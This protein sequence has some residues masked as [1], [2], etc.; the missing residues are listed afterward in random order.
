MRIALVC[1]YSMGHWGGVQ[2][3]AANLAR[4]LTEAGH[5]AW[6]VAPDAA[7]PDRNVGSSRVIRFNRSR[8]PLA[9]HPA[10][11]SAT[12]AAV[13]DAD[14]VHVHEPFMPL[15]SLAA[16]LGDTPPKVGTFHADAGAAVRALYRAGSPVLRRWSRRLA[17][18]TAVSPV[19]QRSVAS[20]VE[21]EIVPNA[22]DVA[23]YDRDVSRRAD[24]VVFVGRD[25]PRKGLDILLTAWVRAGLDAELLVIGAARDDAPA[26]VTFLGRVDED[27]K[28]DLLASASILCAPNTGEESFGLVVAE[29]MAAGCAVVASGIP[30]FAAVLGGD[31]RLVPPGDADALAKTLSNLL[32]EPEQAAAL[33]AAAR[34]AVMRF[35]RSAVVEAYLEAYARAVGAPTG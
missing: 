18:A 31:G 25:D 3:Q 30:A 4:W 16:L 10:A 22:V 9:L 13:A 28:R 21:T 5:E 7:P 23:G 12:V 17:V 15:V 6:L 2:H 20:I 19:A 33:G 26:G 35:D 32:A 24:R 11:R 29:G 34:R 1:P 8:A 27:E 14:V